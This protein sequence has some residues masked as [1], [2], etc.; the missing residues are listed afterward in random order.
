M[1]VGFSESYK[2]LFDDL[3]RFFIRSDGDIKVVIIGKWTNHDSHV[4][5]IVELYRTDQGIPKLEQREV[6]FPMPAGNPPQPLNIR[7][8]ELCNEVVPGRNANDI[9]PLL[10]RDLRFIARD[11][12]A[13]QG[14]LPSSPVRVHG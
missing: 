6:I 5:G 3:N 4:D 11:T 7:R 12:L 8:G 1:Q 10:V 9:L 13:R 2:D 14:L